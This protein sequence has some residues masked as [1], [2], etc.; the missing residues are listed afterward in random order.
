MRAFFIALVGLALV[1]RLRGAPADGEPA[2]S[3]RARSRADPRERTTTPPATTNAPRR[4]ARLCRT[5]RASGAPAAPDHEACALDRARAARAPSGQTGKASLRL[6]RHRGR[7]E[8][9]RTMSALG[10]ALGIAALLAVASVP[11]AA[12]SAEAQFPDP[13]VVAQG[14]DMQTGDPHRT[15]LTHAVNV[16]ANI[17]DTLIGRDASLALRPG[18]AIAWRAVDATT[19]EFKL[20]QGVK[21]HNGEPF[22]AQAVKFSFERMLDPKT[23]WPGAGAL[24]PIKSVTVVDDSTVR[25]TTERPWPLMPRY[26]GY[27]GMIVP[28]ALAQSGEEALIRQPV[29]TGPY[30]FVRWVKDDRV[31]LE[32]NADY[33]G[34]KPRINRVTF[35]AIPSESS[36]LAELLAG[37]VHLMNLVPP[38]LFKP[39]QD[40]SRAKLV[41]GAQPE[42]VLRHREPGQHREG[43]TAGGSARAAGA[44]PRDRPAGHP[45]EHHAQRGEVGPDRVHRGDARVRRVHPAVRLRSRARQG[46]PARGGL[47]E[48]VRLLHLDDQRGLPRRPRHHAGPGRPAHPRGRAHQGQRHRVRR[49]AQDRAG[50]PADRRRVVHAVHRLLRA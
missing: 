2:F 27:Y 50:P 11:G 13:L 48:R 29:G 26:L 34:G 20:R 21:F 17:Y 12:R 37:S 42:R 9:M 18:L 46:A 41:E 33:W 19:W 35:R 40:S 3:R 15:T 32:A 14:V 25:F 1:E 45:V 23:K 31:E 16:L 10:R 47:P 4:G 36:R 44:E 28:P 38:E 22:N 30:K 8:M 24:Q 5:S 7:T 43:Q 39:I 6:R 49:P